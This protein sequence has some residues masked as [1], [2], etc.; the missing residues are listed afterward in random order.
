MNSPFP[1]D[2]KKLKA[3]LRRYERE[4]RKEQA[5][6][7]GFLNDGG[8]KRYM[9]GA[10]YLL[11]GDTT[12][13]ITS[14]NWFEATFPDDSGEPGFFLCWTLAL[15]RAGEPSAATSKLRQT[16]LSN[17]Y[18]I[19]HLLGQA[20]PEY[21]IW[22]G[23]NEDRADYMLYIP[24]E[25]FA[26]WDDNARQ[27]VNEQYHGPEL[28]AIRE[29]YIEIYQQLTNTPPGPQRSALVAEAFRLQTEA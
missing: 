27:W 8:G 17:L 12:G 20:Q 18:L 3:K 1:K 26:L 13:A 2:P 11:L 15:Y 21:D 19:P 14:F 28:T 9:L 7:G 10:M 25:L 5:K 24:P 4:L 6:H 16:M 23:S 29:R 22:H